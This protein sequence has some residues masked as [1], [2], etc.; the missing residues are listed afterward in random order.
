MS[1]AGHQRDWD[2]LGKLDPLW[3]ILT[4]PGTR[5]GR[6]DT[7]KFFATGK[8]EID[9]LMSR[10]RDLGYPGESRLALD[11]G[12]GV[13]RLTRALSAHFTGCV[14]VDISPAMLLSAR[15]YNSGHPS[16]QFILN[17]RN[18][19]RSFPDGHFDL[20]YSNYV[21][22]HMPGRSIIKEI[23][24]EFLRVL[25][26]SGVLVFQLP[27]HIPVKNRLQLRRRLYS[28]LRAVGMNES[29]LYKKLGLHPMRMNFIPEGNVVGLLSLSGARVL[30]VA[31]DKS[32]PWHSA[33]YYVGKSDGTPPGVGA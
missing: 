31:V 3:A 12:C 6:W 33:T 11:F 15:A 21:L 9:E 7:E 26:P 25:K 4:E 10:V 27:S 14:G 22:Q 13:G 28:L 5:F 32:R 17:E 8:Q 18:D 16:C 30:Q 24:G 19:L 23:I 1:S 2:D 29:F 20:I